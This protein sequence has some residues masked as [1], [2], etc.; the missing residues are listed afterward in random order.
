M[1]KD[2]SNATRSF[3]DQIRVEMLSSTVR[4]LDKQV[5]RTKQHTR[6]RRAAAI[7]RCNNDTDFPHSRG[8]VSPTVLTS[9]ATPTSTLDIVTFR[10][11]STFLG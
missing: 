6:V 3:N 10:L 8:Q 11:V 9:G 1:K 2:F 5:L 7:S 4:S